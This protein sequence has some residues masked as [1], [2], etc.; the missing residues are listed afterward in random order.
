V[1]G[2]AQDPSAFVSKTPEGQ[3]LDVLVR[4]ARCGGCLSKI[5]SGV[6]ALPGVTLA[7]L[8]LSTGRMRVEW[9]GELVSRRI[10]ETLTGLGYG[11][12]AFDP[13][14]ADDAHRRTE[15]R[16]LIAM[17]VAAFAS[18]N[19]MLLSISVWSGVLEMSVETRTLMYWVSALIAVPTVAYAGMPFFESA[20]A[21]IR[22]RRMNMDVPITLALVL[23]TGMSLYETMRGGP[24]AYYDAACTLLFFL[25]IGRFLDARLRRRA[26]A[27]ANALAALQAATANRLSRAGVVEAVRASDIRPGDRILVAA[28]ERLAVDGE[29]ISGA[30][31]VDLRMV[32]GEVEPVPVHPGMRLHSGSVNLT[33]P[34]TV[35]ALARADQSLMADVA[36]M[37][38][39]GE[40]KKSAYRRIADRASE[41]YV[42]VV[43]ATAL[44]GFAGWMLAGATLEHA[45]F[46]AVTVLIITC[47]C[48]LALAA[49]VVQVVAAGR[50]FREG[51]FLASGDALERIAG[52]DHVVFDKTGTLT[53]G[54]PTLLPGVNRPEDLEL[55]ARLARASRHPFSRA[56]ARAAGSGPIAGGIEETPGQG[57]RGEIDGAA[58]RLGSAAFVG[59][60]GAAG[61]SELWLRVGDREPVSF[62]FADVLR[63]ASRETVHRLAA[64]GITAE[65]L[66][67]DSEVRVRLAAQSAGIDVWTANATPVSKAAR[68][69]ALEREG[70]KVLM[71]GDGLNDA[72]ALARAHA[73]L[74]PGGAADVARL[75]SDCVFSGDSLGSVARIIQLARSARARMLENFGFS[76]LYNVVAVPVALAGWATPMVAAIA[77]SASSLVVTLN[78]LRMA[79]RWARPEER[80]GERAFGEPVRRREGAA[81]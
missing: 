63:P 47:P 70:R 28:G 55:A 76:A 6:G 52:V 64:M 30:S 59:V 26:W 24:H 5:E 27:A 44:L 58:A 68:L 81:T 20:W 14:E 38:E 45:V 33:R 61:G 53:L 19:I 15:R 40:Q 54:D 65:V 41:I 9:R 16:L 74:A 42:P 25:L 4:G 48:A 35:Q 46:V 75:A 36:R 12:A 51:A 72:G 73:S 80:A 1:D 2:P 39:A 3:A 43:H 32:T 49:P 18:S 8:N 10:I 7:R 29:V 23:A 22:A 13:G 77:M 78:A 57:V 67:G 69:D 37:L 56:L 21:S 71:V 66:S 79:G 34:V 60:D 11:A 31:E 50:L 17:A 62:R